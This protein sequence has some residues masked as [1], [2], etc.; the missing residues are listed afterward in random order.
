VD[1]PVLEVRSDRRGDARINR[2]MGSYRGSED[3][4]RNVMF[5]RLRRDYR[6]SARSAWTENT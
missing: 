1:E 6:A 5:E 3:D 4:I 2:S